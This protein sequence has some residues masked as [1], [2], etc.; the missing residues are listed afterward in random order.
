[1][2]LI[3]IFDQT[4]DSLVPSY[5]SI[6]QEYLSDKNFV[7]NIELSVPQNSMIFQLP[8]APFPEYPSINKMSVHSHF[9]GYL[10]SKDIRWSYGSMKGRLG[11]SWQSL[12]AGMPVEDII[13]A[14]SMCGFSGIYLDTKGYKDGGAKLLSNI[15]QVLEVKPIISDNKRLYFFSMMRY[16][17]QMWANLSE[18]KRIYV[19]FGPGW[20]GIENWTGIHTRWMQ[21]D[22]IIWAISSSNITANLNMQAL[23]FY[24]NRTLMVISGD[25]PVGQL[26]VPTNFI[27]VSV[28]IHFAKGANI[29]SLHL[30][31]GCER[32][33]DKHVLN[34]PDSR[35]LSI[36]VQNLT[37]D[38][39]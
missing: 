2:L 34:N 7:N 23:S 13:K 1:L 39:M 30:P 18:N 12:V 29:V 9:R 22:A 4:S 35:C 38:G 24:R 19:E 37:V 16:N 21:G 10:N 33:F 6:K 26:V 3:G 17:Q 8:Y 36:A 27:N 31:E 32:P 15:R 20:H 14:L 11:D 28:P 5:I 25:V